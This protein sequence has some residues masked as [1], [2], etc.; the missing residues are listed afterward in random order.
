LKYTLKN[1]KERMQKVCGEWP[2][3]ELDPD[4]KEWFQGFEK[5]LRGLL[6]QPIGHFPMDYHRQLIREILGEG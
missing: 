3:S 4:F 1:L 2:D 5:E 6:K